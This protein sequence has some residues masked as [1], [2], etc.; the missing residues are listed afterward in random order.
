MQL[1]WRLWWCVKKKYIKPKNPVEKWLI[2]ARDC[3]SQPWEKWTKIRH[4]QHAQQ[5]LTQLCS[6][7]ERSRNSKGN[8]CDKS[9]LFVF[10][11]YN[12]FLWSVLHVLYIM[13]TGVRPTTFITP[14]P[15]PRHAQSSTLW[16]RRVWNDGWSMRGRR[17]LKNSPSTRLAVMDSGVW[18]VPAELSETCWRVMVGSRPRGELSSSM[19]DLAACRWNLVKWKWRFACRWKNRR[20]W[21]A[22]KEERNIF[23]STRIDWISKKKTGMSV[24]GKNRPPCPKRQ[25]EG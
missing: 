23:F 21:S 25:Y 14:S 17:T 20:F 19:R 7:Y 13:C 15:P 16:V 24:S 12:E 5:T 11:I 3:A 2:E 1:Q 18:W 9:K 6:D 4:S 8:P 22:L 10:Q